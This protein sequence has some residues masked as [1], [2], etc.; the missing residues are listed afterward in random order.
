MTKPT[1]WHVHPAK[2]QISRR[3]PMKK[4]W[5][6]SYPMGAQQ[7][8]WSD[9]ADAQAGLSLRS[10]HMPLCWFCHEAAHFALIETH[11]VFLIN[12]QI[13][14]KLNFCFRVGRTNVQEIT[15]DIVGSLQRWKSRQGIVSWHFRGL[16][17]IS[18][19]RLKWSFSTII[20]Y[21]SNNVR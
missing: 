13:D 2:P 17:D 20:D 7:R 5:L 16:F 18:R 9:W 14:F 8:L 4:A 11:N 12:S 3:I 10:A 15:K 19:F 6:L 1:K 21:Y